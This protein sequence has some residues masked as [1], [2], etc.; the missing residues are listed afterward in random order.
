MSTRG[1]A[2]VVFCIDSSGSMKPCIEGVRNHITDFVAGLKSDQQREWDLRLDFVSHYAGETSGGGYAFYSRSLYN[3]NPALHEALYEQGTGKFFTSEVEDFKRGLGEIDV[4]AD[5]ATLM[6]LDSCLD[7]PWREA[8]ECH[9]VVVLMTDEAIETGVAVEVQ[10]AR[11]DALIDKIQKLR[12][13]LFLVAPNSEAF[14]ALS[15]ADKSEYEPVTAGGD[16]LATVDFKEILSYVGK[17]VSVGVNL[18]QGS[19]PTPSVQRGLFGQT[20]W[21]ESSE[22]L[23][24]D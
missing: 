17:S 7:F 20:G 23:T 14:D 13:M 6:A 1:R 11:I 2:D 19:A 12:I 10:K 8:G 24:G 15:A 16:G 22:A 4:G 21:G 3:P 9:R 5:E 18:Q